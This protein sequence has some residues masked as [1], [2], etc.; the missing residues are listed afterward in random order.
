[1]LLRLYLLDQCLD[2]VFQTLIKTRNFVTF[3]Q[4][5]DPPRHAYMCVKCV[6]R[7]RVPIHRNLVY[8]WG[9]T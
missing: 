5:F 9:N 1:M 8:F 2:P 3:L 4:V 6:P 7:H